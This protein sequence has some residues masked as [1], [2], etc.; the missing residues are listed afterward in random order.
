MLLVRKSARHGTAASHIS[1]NQA[2]QEV[3][4][5]RNLFIRFSILMSGSIVQELGNS[6]YW[7]NVSGF[8]A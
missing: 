5:T 8:L 3:P 4:Q 6:I 7:K 2:V 1:S